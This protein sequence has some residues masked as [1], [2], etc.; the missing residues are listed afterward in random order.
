[1]S[2]GHAKSS[3]ERMQITSSSR[4]TPVHLINGSNPSPSRDQRNPLDL[5][6]LR[7]HIELAMSV[8]LDETFGSF[9]VNLVSDFHGIEKVGDDA[10]GRVAWVG[11]GEVDFDNEVKCSL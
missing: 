11:L 1:M 9:H 4:Q 2:C 6:I 8:V 7:G 5:Q 10:S 3:S